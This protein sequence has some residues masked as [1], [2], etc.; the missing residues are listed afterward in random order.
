M[1]K[2]KYA[3]FEALDLFFVVILRGLS[4]LVDGESI[5]LPMTRSSSPD[6]TF[7]VGL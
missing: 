7:Q 3:G 5:R 4:G 6:I 1:E 2:D